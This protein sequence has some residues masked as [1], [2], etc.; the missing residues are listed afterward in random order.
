[1]DNLGEW[2]S[3]QYRETTDAIEREATKTSKVKIPHQTLLWT[4][5]LTYDDDPDLRER[6]A[7]PSTTGQRF[8][9]CIE[10]ALMLGA[11]PVLDVSRMSRLFKSLDQIGRASGSLEDRLY[12][13]YKVEVGAMDVVKWQFDRLAGRQWFSEVDVTSETQVSAYGDIMGQYLHGDWR[14]HPIPLDSVADVLT[15][16]EIKEAG[17]AGIS[18]VVQFFRQKLEPDMTAEEKT[19]MEENSDDDTETK[20]KK[21]KL[22]R[23][24]A[25]QRDANLEPPLHTAY[26]TSDPDTVFSQLIAAVQ[27]AQEKHVAASGI[28]H[29]DENVVEAIAKISPQLRD[30]LLRGLGLKIHRKLQLLR[31]FDVEVHRMRSKILPQGWKEI[32]L[33]AAEEIEAEGLT[34][35]YTQLSSDEVRWEAPDVP[36]LN[37]L[38][39]EKDI[40]IGFLPTGQPFYRKGNEVTYDC[41]VSLEVAIAAIYATC[42][43]VHSKHYMTTFLSIISDEPLDSFKEKE[44][45]S[46][47]KRT[48][49]W[50]LKCVGECWD[51]VIFDPSGQE[52]KFPVS[53]YHQRGPG[54]MGFSRRK[55][56]EEYL[57]LLFQWDRE[58][59]KAQQENK[60][61]PGTLTS[62]HAIGSWKV[63]IFYL[64]DPVTSQ[65]MFESGHLSLERRLPA[66]KD[67]TTKY[68]RDKKKKKM[69]VDYWENKYTKEK[70]KTRPSQ[71]RIPVVRE[72]WVQ[73][74]DARGRKRWRNLIT[75]K[76]SLKKP[77]GPD[78]NENIWTEHLTSAGRR[79]WMNPY[80]KKR[81]FKNPIA[82]KAYNPMYRSYDVYENI[83]EDEE[84]ETT[85]YRT[86]AGNLALAVNR[87]EY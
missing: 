61:T 3:N 66:A 67:W 19:A 51:S 10:V 79:F 1:M 6:V 56:A 28:S 34:S 52:D 26:V 8:F 22:R 46:V 82:V 23:Q 32:E 47:G 20:Q 59:R 77:I 12:V 60:P 13:R 2:F 76:I 21:R 41:P 84:E 50:Y 69:V 75:R 44:S 65:A 86:A 71:S 36:E 83:T 45:T 42:L 15:L 78:P 63:W 35:Y 68:K 4:W 49:L 7:P 38:W 72:N 33:T 58:K 73:E 39:R 14:I 43:S 29:Y 70:T 17:T 40:N 11:S 64:Q 87:T 18:W 9:A 85:Y 48:V 62:D 16:D 55:D 74:E 57:H 25:R 81:V 31:Y 53:H 24:F 80:T 27:E 37:P 54:F 30:W 5:T